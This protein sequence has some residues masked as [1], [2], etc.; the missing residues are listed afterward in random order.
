MRLFGVMVPL[1]IGGTGIGLGFATAS[2]TG[3]FTAFMLAHGIFIG[4]LGSSAMFAPLIADTA[5]W[6][7]RRRGI[8]V[9]GMPMGSPGMEH[10][11]HSEPY[12]TMLIKA[13]GTTSVFAKH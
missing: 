5:L 2:M 1:L 12:S 11:G 10:G 7:V 4:L 8:A 13:D 9:A 6:W 3:N